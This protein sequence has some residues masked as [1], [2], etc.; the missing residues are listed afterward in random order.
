MS[1]LHVQDAWLLGG[2][3]NNVLMSEEQ[4]G[5][6]T[7]QVQEYGPFADF[8]EHCGI[9][10]LRSRGR[11]FTWS[12]GTIHSK[13]DKVLGNTKW[14]ELIAHVEAEFATENLSYHTPCLLHSLV[15][16]NRR[17]LTTFKFCNMWSTDSSFLSIVQDV[18]RQHIHGSPMYQL[19][20]KLKLLRQALK[21]LKVEYSGAAQKVDELRKELTRTQDALALSPD[22]THLQIKEQALKTLLALESSCT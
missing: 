15:E 11:F 14:L 20:A 6:S 9:E 16:H 18:W 1:A 21:P 12:N 22:D 4:I 5:G 17:R 10:D 8:L 3:F 13:I 2:D 19:L 7:P